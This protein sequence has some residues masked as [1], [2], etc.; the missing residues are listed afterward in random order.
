MAKLWNRCATRVRG[1]LPPST[2]DG[3]TRYGGVPS[4][5]MP[6]LLSVASDVSTKAVGIGEMKAKRGADDKEAF[7]LGDFGEVWYGIVER[8][9]RA[10]W[11]GGEEGRAA[12]EAVC[13]L[14]SRVVSSTA[15]RFRF[16]DAMVILIG[17]LEGEG[18]GEISTAATVACG[19]GIGSVMVGGR[20]WPICRRDMIRWCLT[21][22]VGAVARGRRESATAHAKECTKRES[23][24]VE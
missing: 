20:R 13:G 4:I 9:V 21:W 19:G 18:A 10:C 1:L 5:S 12:V 8:M 24:V 7:S 16:E 15:L 23:A 2:D 17:G 11:G 22:S 14:G 3:E 6:S